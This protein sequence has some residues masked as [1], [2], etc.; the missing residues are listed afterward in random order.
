MTREAV[1]VRPAE[2]A[3]T[4]RLFSLIR[5]LAAYENLSDQVVGS[6]DQLRQHLFGESPYAHALIGECGG[7]VAGYAL[8]FYSYSTFLTRPGIY[9]EDLFVIPEMRGRGLGRALLARVAA[10][11]SQ[12]GCGRLEWSVLDWNESALGF[13]RALGA[14]AVDGWTVYRLT[15]AA[16]DGLAAQD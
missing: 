5:A 10:L 15:G 9:L 11:A 3:D 6:Q 8:F 2:V 14:Q 16:L 13:Y 1:C 4:P 7:E 12:R